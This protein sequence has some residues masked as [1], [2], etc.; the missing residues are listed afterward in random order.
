MCWSKFI[1][2]YRDISAISPRYSGNTEQL[3]QYYHT[4]FT[5]YREKS[6]FTAILPKYPHYRVLAALC[7]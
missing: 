1:Y 2:H 3:T 6:A 7:I 4:S 5:R